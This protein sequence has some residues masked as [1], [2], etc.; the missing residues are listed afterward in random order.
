M[1][2]AGVEAIVKPLLTDDIRFQSLDR[3]HATLFATEFAKKQLRL[4]WPDLI[5]LAEDIRTPR[6]SSKT[7]LPWIKLAR[8]GDTPSE[9][10]CLRY[11]NNIEAIYG[12][13]CDIDGKGAGIRE[14]AG[15][16]ADIWTL[17]YTTPSS[18]PAKPH[19]RVLCP[20]SGAYI[21][22]PDALRNLRALLVA[23]VNSRLGGIV[24]GESFVLSQ[25]YYFG[26]VDGRPPIEI[27]VSESK[28][29]I[30]WMHEC[31]AVFKGGGSRETAEK[32]EQ[33]EPRNKPEPRRAPDG[34]AEDDRNPTLLLEAVRRCRR[35]I[36][37]HGIGTQ[38]R[39]W[40]ALGLGAW[41]ADM[42]TFDGK[43]LSLC[44]IAE[45]MQTEGYGE[46]DATLFETRGNPRGCEFVLSAE[47]KARSRG[48][49]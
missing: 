22:A 8:F 3:I 41:L 15:E 30:D 7:E 2:A 36:A 39:G 32:R 4:N 38:P 17:L 16:L 44:R 48:W 35:H 47:E 11:D 21:G 43:I 10:G 42:R 13:E 6:R 45:I 31:G 29:P 46:I 24:A 49:V 19:Y 37:K 9:K 5:V 12:I 33:R 1:S 27:I 23:R 28:T 40:R 18:T 26:N 14:A 34:L 20:L 25:S